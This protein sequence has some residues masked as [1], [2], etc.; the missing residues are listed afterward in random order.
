MV[1][2]TFRNFYYSTGSKI[3]SITWLMFSNNRG[4]PICMALSSFI[5]NSFSDCVGRSMT[6]FLFISANLIHWLAY[7][8][9]SIMRGQRVEFLMMIALSMEKDSFGSFSWF[10]HCPMVMGSA[11]IC[12]SEKFFEN[13]MVFIWRCS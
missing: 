3:G 5:V 12:C 6:R 13:L 11:S 4:Y 1:L 8:W 9:G 7:I 10:V 2:P